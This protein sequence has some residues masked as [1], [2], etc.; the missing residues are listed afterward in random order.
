M[1]RKLLN[2]KSQDL[3]LSEMNDEMGDKE[4]FENIMVNH[5]QSTAT[6]KPKVPSHEVTQQM[7]AIRDEQKDYRYQHRT[8]YS[9]I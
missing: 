1:R 2:M 9:E 3:Q 8:S 4:E 6:D 7:Q 5:K